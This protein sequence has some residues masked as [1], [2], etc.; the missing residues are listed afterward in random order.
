[1]LVTCLWSMVF[2]ENR[3]PP[4]IQSGASF[5]GIMLQTAEVSATLAVPTSHVEFIRGELGESGASN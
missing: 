4:Q 5:S 3:Y 1:M 2:S